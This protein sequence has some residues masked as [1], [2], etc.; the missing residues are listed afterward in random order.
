MNDDYYPKITVTISGPGQTFDYH[1]NVIKDAL[2]NANIKVT[3]I[4]DQPL[5]SYGETLKHTVHFNATIIAD[6]QPWGG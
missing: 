4:N 3:M 1:I 5:S 6:H 2:E